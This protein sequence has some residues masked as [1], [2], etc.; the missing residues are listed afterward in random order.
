MQ[1]GYGSRSPPPKGKSEE[2]GGPT[3]KHSK[4][5]FTSPSS[6]SEVT[7]FL[8]H[9]FRFPRWGA[10][11]VERKEDRT[12]NMFKRNQGGPKEEGLTSVDIRVWTCKELRAKHYQTSC[13]SRPPFLG[14]PLIS[15]R[16][17]KLERPRRLAGDVEKRSLGHPGSAGGADQDPH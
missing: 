15:P 1:Q 12:P 14:T 2:G 6:H 3:N 7:T 10:A 9:P 5:T 17:T 4:V 13:S 11:N 8:D 16:A